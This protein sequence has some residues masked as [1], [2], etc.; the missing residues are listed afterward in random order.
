MS[1]L[2][3]RLREV[4]AE[5]QSEAW[6]RQDGGQDLSIGAMLADEAADYITA[7]EAQLAATCQRE[8]ATCQRHDAKVAALEAQLAAAQIID[9]LHQPNHRWVR[10]SDAQTAIKALSARIAP[11]PEDV[12][13]VCRKLRNRWPVGGTEDEA[14]DMIETQARE[15]A[16]LR[17]ALSDMVVIAEKD[18]WPEALSGRQLIYSNARTALKGRQP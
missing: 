4:S 7:I 10:R 2:V 5:K 17:E 14:A 1:D 13:L 3:D 11:L 8:A 6:G 16:L 18:C 12:A 9:G 15:L